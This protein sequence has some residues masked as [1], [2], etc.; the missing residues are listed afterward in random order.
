MAYYNKAGRIPSKR[1]VV[2]SK[3]DTSLYQEELVG[4]QGFSGTSSFVYHLYP[5][6]M[7]EWIEGSISVEPKLAIRKGLKCRSFLTF[8]T[9]ENQDYIESRKILLIN[10]DLQISVAAPQKSPDYFY[11]N[12]DADELNTC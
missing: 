6:T 10:K 5:P 3:G 8:Q 4:T 9:E 12:A 11:K 7:V 1:H 2:F